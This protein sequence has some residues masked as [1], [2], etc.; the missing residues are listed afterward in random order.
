MRLDVIASTLALSM[1]LA[2]PARGQSV[3]PPKTTVLSI[4]PLSAVF[5][6][7]SAEVEH[8]VSPT[9]TVG[10]GGSYW[11]WSDDVDEVRYSSADL[12]LRYYPEAHPFQGFSFGGQL[13]FTSVTDRALGYGS[14]GTRT[15]TSGPAVGVGLDYNWL[16]GASRSF[17][18]GLGLG[19]KKIFATSKDAGNAHLAY[20]TGRISIGYA[21]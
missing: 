5:S 18:V 15:K 1:V 10:A 13:G 3:T 16:L 20:P 19:A 14:A 4:Q 12:K 11:N 17:Y 21:F 9:I 7:Y 2:L 8:A 6:V